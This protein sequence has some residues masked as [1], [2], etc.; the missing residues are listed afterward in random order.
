MTAAGTNYGNLTKDQQVAI[1]AIERAGSVLS[2]LGCV[3]IIVTFS[4]SKAFHKPINRLVFYASFGNLMTNVAT[5]M[6]RDFVYSQDSVGCQFQAA[7]IQMFMPADALWTL[8]MAVNV[9]LT[10]YHKFD[11]ERLRKMEVWY[12]LFCYGIPFIPA[13]VFIFVTE[14]GRGRMYGNA[15]LWCWIAAEWDVM[16]IAMFYGPVWVVIIVTFAIYLRAGRDIYNK[17]RQL[18]YFSSSHDRTDPLVT[19]DD[20]YSHKTT[21][22]SVTTEDIRNG[23]GNDDI[24]LSTLGP[25]V[26]SAGTA[27]ASQQYSVTISSEVRPDRN[28]RPGFVLPAQS[29][30]QM[31]DPST[32]RPG[33]TRRRANMEANNAAWSYARC[34][35]LF[36]TAICITWLPSSA[37][38]VYSVVHPG[39]ASVPLEFMSAVVLPL[40]GFWNAVI[41][42]STS[43]SA[44]KYFISEMKDRSKRS[45]QTTSNYPGEFAGRNSGFKI[46]SRRPKQNYE[47]ESMT[48]LAIATRPNSN[49]E[50]KQRD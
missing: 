24:D 14:A 50:P 7:L 23:N 25:I 5:L 10:F 28:S 33:R 27:Q 12:F 16:R 15:A 41:Y 45:E 48:E 26:I 46:T 18:R 39:F 17:R 44:C 36:F 29:N 43:W 2:I 9:Y 6:A 47:T 8:A 31:R 30:T 40:Q 42:I 22:V 34:A 3:I 13:L 37:N 38:R 49:D 1:D 19:M 21:E 4:V 35:I 11:A 20:P 32:A